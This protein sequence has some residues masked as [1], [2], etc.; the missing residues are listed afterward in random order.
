MARELRAVR[1]QATQVNH[2]ADPRGTGGPH[3]VAGGLGLLGDEVL[4]RAHRVHE[5]VDD[6]HPVECP[7]QRLGFGQVALRHLHL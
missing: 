5:V 1:V 7:R 2:P 6:V 4:R 3:H